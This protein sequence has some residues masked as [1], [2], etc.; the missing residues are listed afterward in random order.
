MCK[1]YSKSHITSSIAVLEVHKKYAAV[2]DIPCLFWVGNGELGDVYHPYV[3]DWTESE[4]PATILCTHSA[5][6]QTHHCI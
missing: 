4:N 6:M 5:V 2:S 1:C 3:D